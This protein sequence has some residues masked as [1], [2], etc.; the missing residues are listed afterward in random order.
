VAQRRQFPLR[1]APPPPRA[2]GALRRS[3]E[4]WSGGKGEGQTEPVQRRRAGEG[5]G[6]GGG[7]RSE[8][9]DLP[10]P[11]L[12]QVGSQLLQSFAS[13]FFQTIMVNI[14]IFIIL[15]YFFMFRTY[16]N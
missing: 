2:R 14:F 13:T 16:K 5:V 9:R 10:P 1:R 8:R 15:F 4:A 11:R 7:E 6:R 12:H 3:G